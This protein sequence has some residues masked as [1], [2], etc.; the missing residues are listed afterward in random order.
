[1]SGVH[2]WL[3]GYAVGIWYIQNHQVPVAGSARKV[4]ELHV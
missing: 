1:M 2:T 3:S 4:H